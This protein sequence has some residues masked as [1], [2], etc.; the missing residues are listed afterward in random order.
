MTPTTKHLPSFSIYALEIFADA[1]RTLSFTDTCN[2]L[3]TVQSQVSK[4][5]D[6]LEKELGER[7][8]IRSQKPPFLKLT[9]AGKRLAPEAADIV[10]RCRKM[11]DMLRTGRPSPVH[12]GVNEAIQQTWLSLW[13]ELLLVECPRGSWSI[14]VVATAMQ[15]RAAVEGTLDLCICTE[16]IRPD[17]WSHA[18]LSPMPMAFFGSAQHYEDRVYT[19]A[20]L[21]QQHMFT[22]QKGSLPA[23]QLERVLSENNLTP[24]RLEWLSSIS[25]MIESVLKGTAVVALPLD[26]VARRGPNS[27]LRLLRCRTELSSLRMYVSVPKRP[28]DEVRAVLD[29]LVNFAERQF[30]RRLDLR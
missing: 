11:L 9:E 26:V 1:A 29:T 22:F 28:R 23:D 19:L 15:R 17:D 16:R 18:E 3:G 25:E 27:G 30:G 24:V 2:N 5:V 20:E 14:E 4:H 10:A 12:V 8:F 21:A 13:R 7:L 6:E